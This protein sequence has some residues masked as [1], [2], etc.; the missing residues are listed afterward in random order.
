VLKDP[1]AA[2]PIARRHSVVSSLSGGMVVG[3]V[4]AT[5]RTKHP[6]R[7]LQAVF[8]HRKGKRKKKRGAIGGKIRANR[9]LS[10]REGEEER[11]EEHARKIKMALTLTGLCFGAGKVVR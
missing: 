3:S 7:T 10:Q 6:K 1:I 4:F 11:A 8:Y 5:P 2:P 9:N